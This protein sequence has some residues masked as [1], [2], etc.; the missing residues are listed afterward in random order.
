MGIHLKEFVSFFTFLYKLCLRIL[1]S[2]LE[3]CKVQQKRVQHQNSRATVT[4]GRG[5]LVE[6]DCVPQHPLGQQRTILFSQRLLRFVRSRF[7]PYKAAAFENVT[8][9]LQKKKVYP[10]QGLTAALS[11]PSASKFNIAVFPMTLLSLFIQLSLS[12]A[13]EFQA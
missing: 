6:Q 7:W 4:L 13:H 2:A 9:H 12:F 10:N 8:L 5:I 1:Y 11:E 3:S